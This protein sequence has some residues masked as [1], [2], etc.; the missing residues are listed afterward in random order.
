MA[1]CKGWEFNPRQCSPPALQPAI[2]PLLGAGVGHSF[3]LILPV[4][5]VA[6]PMTED[7]ERDTLAPH[8]P[9]VPSEKG[10]PLLRGV[11]TRDGGSGEET[12]R[13]EL[14]TR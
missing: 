14:K 11:C 10:N 3:V 4:D 1:T 13:N 6:V 5:T 9:C 12:A 7:G 2:F 8:R